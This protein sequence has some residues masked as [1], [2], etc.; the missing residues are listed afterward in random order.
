M[1]TN[2]Y[3]PN[4][5]QTP[6]AL[7][8]ELMPYLTPEEFVVLSYA[9]RH[10]LGWEDTLA[11]R[12]RPMSLEFFINGIEGNP[13]V[14]G[15][16]LSKPAVMKAL[17]GLTQ[18]GLMDKIGPVTEAGQEW[19]LSY[20]TGQFDMEGLI[21][22]R[23]EKRERGR[24]RTQLARESNPK[25]GVVSPTDRGSV[26]LTGGGQ[27]DR[28]AAVSPTDTI[29]HTSQTHSQTQSTG[30]LAP[31]PPRR[32]SSTKKTCRLLSK[33]VND[34]KG[35]NPYWNIICRHSLK[36]EWRDFTPAEQNVHRGRLQ[37]ILNALDGLDA[38][39][40]ITP[41]ELTD[42]YKWFRH[43]HPDAD[44][45]AGETTVATM[46]TNYRATIR[47]SN[48]GHRNNGASK[49]RGPNPNCPVCEGKGWYR[50]ENGRDYSCHCEE[51]VHEPIK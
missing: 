36:T 17:D 29:K 1:T 14:N 30:A 45:P 22:R 16:G 4:S 26:P 50:A 38:E 33:A 18:F 43:E 10:I 23:D 41:E 28:P 5:F 13:Y 31:V 32:R 11:K 35:Q 20:A 42:A 21:Q 25:N 40:P 15:C 12:S 46:L 39:Q 2:R 49:P 51:V 27:S 9:T 6:N 48:N 19:G 37:S 44:Y 34:D 8:D 7:V 24:Q 47:K 3:I